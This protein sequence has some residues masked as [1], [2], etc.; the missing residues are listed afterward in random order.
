MKTIKELALREKRVFIRTD[1]N[2]PMD[3][4]KNIT[5]A[6][7][8]EAALPTIKYALDH[9]SRI[10]LASHLGR[11]KGEKNV[12]YSLEPV[13]AKLA[14]LLDREVIF[15]EDCIGMGAQQMVRDLKPGNIVVLENLRFYAE[16][17]ANESGFAR[18]LAKLC[19]VYINDA[20]GVSHREHASV[21]S[22][23][24]LVDDSAAG[25]LME[26]EI[27]ELSK[28][29]KYKQGEKFTAILGGAKVSDKIGIIRSLLEN[30]DTLIVGGAMAYTFLAA[31]GVKLGASLVEK[32]KIDVAK[33]ILKGAEARNV[34]V[35]LPTDHIAAES[36]ESTETSYYT[37]DD[38]PSEMMGFDI[39]DKT[40]DEYS[41]A[42]RN[43]KVIFWNGPMGVF[44]KEQFEKGSV[45]VSNVVA[46]SDAYTVAGGGDTVALINKVGI[47][48]SV[49]HISTGGG[50]SLK[51][52]KSKT[53]PG[54]E[55]L[56]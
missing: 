1:F 15:F 7:R 23:P 29:F 40:I 42:I 36:I 54:I 10:I 52:L 19:D 20:F 37:N 28:L 27:E 32:D 5:D 14:E 11:P 3:E 50:A 16:E 30:V 43:S 8:I 6:T 49:D 46:E 18:E 21:H 31:K 34:R 44:E 9:N 4:E 12:E 25:F 2:V 22:L 24:K 33:E 56:K 41:E 35:M 51:F 26:K 48:S 39:G 55:V 45:I 53:L 17:E 38:F 47:E 13:A